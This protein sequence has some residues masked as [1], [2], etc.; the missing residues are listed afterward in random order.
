MTPPWHALPLEFWSR[1]IGRTETAREAAELRLVC[2]TWNPIAERVMFSQQ[3]HFKRLVKLKK[4]Y[5]H[6]A[7]RPFLGRWIR[8]LDIGKSDM[9]SLQF[10][11]HFLELAF[12]S[13]IEHVD[14]LLGNEFYKF[15]LDI[16]RRSPVKFSKIKSL[17]HP[18]HYNITYVTT[19]LYFKD[20]LQELKV[21]VLE[22]HKAAQL[23]LNRL[24]EFHSLTTLTFMFYDD[25]TRLAQLEK[26]LQ[27]CPPQVKALKLKLGNCR[28]E[29]PLQKDD[30]EQ[31]LKENVAK[32][33]S[34][35][36]LH[37]DGNTYP[38]M[39]D[40]LLYKFPDITGASLYGYDLEFEDGA[41]KRI[42]D[43]IKSLNYAS[44]VG[45]RNNT[46]QDMAICISTMNSKISRVIIKERNSPLFTGGCFSA[47]RNILK[48]ISNF[49]L[50]IPSKQYLL[51]IISLIAGIRYLDISFLPKKSSGERTA[52]RGILYEILRRTP[53]V[54][55]LKFADSYIEK[56]LSDITF[57]LERLI[58]VKI[59]GAIIEEGALQNLS[60][61]APNLKHLSLDTCLLD[62]T[63]C[64][65]HHIA[66]P[67]TEFYSLS[68]Y[69]RKFTAEQL[70]MNY[71]STMKDL[72]W[73]S[74]A[75]ELDDWQLMFLEVTTLADNQD[76][77]FV[78]RPGEVSLCKKISKKDFKRD[79][80]EWPKISI[81]CSSLN[82][83]NID[84]GQLEIEIDLHEKYQ[85][86]VEI[87]EWKV[88]K[89]SPI[90]PLMSD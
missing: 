29:D 18:V 79:I 48:G 30:L 67:T 42:L 41:V 7:K 32:S 21:L 83:L 64:Q 46:T 88:D 11:R 12:T 60:R 69:A 1:V 15:M 54:K 74:K 50:T 71:S 47:A 75:T 27:K 58:D 66:M 62:T 16:A 52:D 28:N 5:S 2:K 72:L 56:P 89:K 26:I 24:H 82:H 20:S 45:W 86:V 8:Y 61:I 44:I 3:L 9:M 40:Y 81:T 49:D 77:Y 76:R 19:L 59:V 4:F 57:T 73:I 53:E 65:D 70:E 10:Q 37:V 36:A 33:T 13:N 38:M 84:L 31:W 35:W 68:I 55:Y 14:G 39:M 6:L 80:S 51:H 25:I 22:T 43:T 17:A 34:V 90:L 85:S 78:L 87:G 63:S 23:V